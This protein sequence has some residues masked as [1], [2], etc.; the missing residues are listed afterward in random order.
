MGLRGIK[1]FYRTM[2]WNENHNASQ[3]DLKYNRAQIVNYQRL[4]TFGKQIIATTQTTL[5]FIGS[6]NYILASFDI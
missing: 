1:P 6:R 4:N 2:H 3:I 5:H